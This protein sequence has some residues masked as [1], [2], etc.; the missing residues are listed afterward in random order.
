MSKL[1][2]AIAGRLGY[3]LTPKHSELATSYPDIRE[4]EFW[5]LYSLCKPFTM[6]SV[7]RL[8]A[9]Y[10]ATKY[11]LDTG[12]EGD[13]VEC[14]VWRGGSA[15]MMAKMLADRGISNR[16]VYLFDTFEGMSEPTS[17][18]KSYDGKSADAQLAQHTHNKE[19]S[20]WCLAELPDV[21]NNLKKSGLSDSQLVFIKGKVE[22]TLPGG[23]TADKIAL[24]RLD[25]DWYESTL[26]E[27]QTLYPTLSKGGALIIDDYGHWEGCRKAVDEYFQAHNI[28][29]ILNRIDYTGRM[30]IKS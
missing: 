16:K 28:H 23:C 17:R 6:T 30:G 20:V 29:M 9:L 26:H 14:G 8:Y 7:S 22:D 11:V 1:L 18:D 4:E 13:F 15:L 10:Q 24:L 27:L 3:T 2:A 21:I 5:A 12:I 25:T 19:T